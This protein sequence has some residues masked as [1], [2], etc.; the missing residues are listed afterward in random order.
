LLLLLL[1]LLLL[2]T[3]FPNRSCLFSSEVYYTSFSDTDVYSVG[4]ATQVRASAVI[5]DCGELEITALDYQL[6]AY[7]R[8]TLR[9]NKI[10]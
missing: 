3:V 6:V 1:L 8:T 9:L 10:N 4:P 7:F 5:A 2:Y